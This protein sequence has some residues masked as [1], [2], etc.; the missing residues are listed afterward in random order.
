MKTVGGGVLEAIS[1]ACVYKQK[2]YTHVI[3]LQR[4]RLKHTDLINRFISIEI[5]HQYAPIMDNNCH[6]TI[7]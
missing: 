2:M 4:S 1:K 7:A 5:T 3:K 6:S